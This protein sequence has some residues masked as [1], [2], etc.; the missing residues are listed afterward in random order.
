EVLVALLEHLEDIHVWVQTPEGRLDTFAN[1]GRS[2]QNKK[3]VLEGLDSQTKCGSFAVV[4]KTKGDNFGYFLMTQQSAAT[5]ET[6]R[7]AVKAIRAPGDAPGFLV[8]LREANGGNELFAR[9]IASQ[10]CAKEAVYAR[11]KCRTGKAHDALGPLQ[12]RVLPACDRPFVRPV[13]C[14]IGQRCVSSGEGFAQMMRCLPNVTTV[15]ERTRG[16]SGNPRPF[17]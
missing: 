11:S 14:L 16:A 5:E 8:D 1:P 3:V 12:E 2:N 4:G 9:Q 10:F 13:V 17:T 6:V 15:G 7:Q